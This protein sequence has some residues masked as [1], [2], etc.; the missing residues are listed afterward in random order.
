MSSSSIREFVDAAV[1]PRLASLLAEPATVV[2]FGHPRRL[3]EIPGEP[4]VLCAWSGDELMQRAAAKRLLQD[5][6]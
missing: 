4:A 5:G 3:E 1:D 6:G 2:L